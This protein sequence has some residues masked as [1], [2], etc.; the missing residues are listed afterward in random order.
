[1]LP[2]NEQIKKLTQSCLPD[3]GHH[4]LL[5]NLNS[6]IPDHHF[7]LALTRG[8]WHRLGGVVTSTGERVCR[9]IIEWVKE[10]APGGDVD[11]L[12]RNYIEQDLQVT[13]I[14][15]STLY[16]VAA[17]GNNADQFLQIEVELLR[18]QTD[19]PLIDEDRL[20]EDLEELIDPIDPLRIKEHRLIQP[21]WYS[22]RRILDVTDLTSQIKQQHARRTT[23][24][25]IHPLLRFMDEWDSSSA[26]QT[27]HFS[28]HWVLA[29]RDLDD[30]HGDHLLSVKPVSVNTLDWPALES[31]KQFDGEHRAKLIHGLD[32]DSKTPFAWFF[33]IIKNSS[34]AGQDLLAAVSA[35]LHRGYDYLPLKD[36]RII[37][38]W[39]MSPYRP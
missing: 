33:Q 35:D 15:G 9:D 26:G 16:M 2:D 14:Q 22:C 28:D 24:K 27:S 19:R 21:A 8:G 30:Q 12:I 29:V 10:E 38:D 11:E 7:Q 18:E 5:E 6:K 3:P 32:H 31:A 20:P 17:T 23:R 4:A 34:T 1:M 36:A 39:L 25:S 37:N 13:T